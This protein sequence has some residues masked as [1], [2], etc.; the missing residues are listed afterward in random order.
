MATCRDL[1]HVAYR[2]EREREGLFGNIPR[3]GFGVAMSCGVDSIDH[4]S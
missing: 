4:P 2:V 3:S 1:R